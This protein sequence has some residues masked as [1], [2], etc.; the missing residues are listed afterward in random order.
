MS[1][2]SYSRSKKFLGS[3][4]GSDKDLKIDPKE[5]LETLRDMSK[6]C[7]LVDYQDQIAIAS[8]GVRSILDGK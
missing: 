7:F 2:L 6:D 8:G 3:W 4:Q 1:A 5:I